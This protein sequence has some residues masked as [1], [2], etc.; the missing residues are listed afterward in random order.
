MG[1]ISRLARGGDGPVY[2]KLFPSGLDVEKVLRYLA[3][4]PYP[5]LLDSGI[6]PGGL[7]RY[8][9]L[10][11]DPFLV[12]RAKGYSVQVWETGE[13][14]S[15][16]SD[17]LEVLRRYLNRYRLEF[18]NE[19]PF[20]GGAVGYLAYDLGRL[21]ERIP[22]WAE[23]DL[24]LPDMYMCFYDRILA[25]DKENDYAYI[26]STGWPEN[27]PELAQARARKRAVD[28]YD[29]LARIMDTSD[30]NLARGTSR[31]GYRQA[32]EEVR[33]TGA[34]TGS[35]TPEGCR[36]LLDKIRSDFTRDTYCRAVA[37][38]LDYIRAGDIFQVNLS[39]RFELDVSGLLSPADI[40]LALRRINPTPFAAFLGYPEASVVCAS[41]ERF[42]RVAG[43][44]VETRPIKGTRPRGKNPDEDE[45]MRRELWTSEK[46]RAEL[47]MIVDLERNDLGRV[48]RPGSV[49]V[50]HLFALEEY[51]TVFHLVSTVRGELEEGKDVVD[52]LRATFPGGSITG[53]PKVRSMEI[54][55]ELE[56][57][58]RGIYTGS[59]GYLGFNGNTDLNIVIR[60]LVIKGGKAYLQVGGGIVADS[61][62][63]SE[64]EETLHKGRALFTALGVSMEE[65][66]I[67]SVM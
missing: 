37:R 34:Y 50:P 67:C 2:V 21:V 49:H 4:L 6:N 55:E 27:V 25:V 19:L 3:R 57:V 64:Y 15:S 7:G 11:W 24:G 60:T 44:M 13:W 23:D 63:E 5:F 42:L 8:F 30:R 54:I 20:I 59:I 12:L 36:L 53:A 22:S 52:L 47:V 46:D 51:A 45:R 32:F 58:R 66:G 33:G 14:R 39:Q 56:P 43:R 65:L 62:P 35:G 38:A 18:G 40:F 1:A 17:P 28:L 61:Q 9:F 31:R 16:R 10:G 48:C 26:V 41:P 29:L